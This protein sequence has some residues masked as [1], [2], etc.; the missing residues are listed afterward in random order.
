MNSRLTRLLFSFLVMT[1]TYGQDSTVPPT[2]SELE[3]DIKYLRSDKSKE[4][5]S[6]DENLQI[7]RYDLEKGLSLDNYSTKQDSFRITAM[8]NFNV[9]PMDITGVTGFEFQAAKKLDHAWWEFYIA[10]S[11]AV[12]SSVTKDNAQFPGFSNEQI[13]QQNLTTLSLG[14]G[15]SYRT[16]L[17]QTLFSSDN[18]FETVGAMLSYNSTKT[19]LG[20]SYSGPG[21]KA[22]FGLHFR[23]SETFH[24]GGRFNYNLAQVKRAATTDGETSSARSLLL[25]WTTFAVDV[26]F[27]F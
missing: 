16:S 9:D 15:I 10:Q 5:K 7:K 20:E 13:D 24:W 23:S 19:E 3:S 11:S 26:S 2:D 1:S 25:Q 6:L 17:I 8:Y 27:Y 14:T 21:L 12:L 18:L 22:D 4:D